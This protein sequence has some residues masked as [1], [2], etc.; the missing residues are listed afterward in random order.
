MKKRQNMFS[1][2]FLFQ[3]YVFLNI[4]IVSLFLDCMEHGDQYVY[5]HVQREF[6]ETHVKEIQNIVLSLAECNAAGKP[7]NK[8]SRTGFFIVFVMKVLSFWKL[9]MM[10]KEDKEKLN[11]LGIDY[12]LIKSFT[13]HIHMAKGKSRFMRYLKLENVIKLLHT[14]Y[15]Y[16]KFELS[17]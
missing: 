11:S 7:S 13:V 16:L 4:H 12:F 10:Q 3:M 2:N 14:T 1:L 6:D 17:T 8:K 9:L 15:N 5:F